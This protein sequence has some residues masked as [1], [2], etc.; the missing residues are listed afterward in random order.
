ML[1]GLSGTVNRQ[2]W[3]ER[4]GE[5]DVEDSIAEDLIAN[6]YAIRVASAKTTAAVDPVEEK[7]AKPVA[8]ARKSTTKE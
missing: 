2:P 3:P 6:G 7:A 5:I 4:E 1:V 8:K